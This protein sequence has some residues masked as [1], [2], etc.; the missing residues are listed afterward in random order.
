MCKLLGKPTSNSWPGFFDV[1]NH[2]HLLSL[3]SEYKS[4]TLPEKFKGM[5]ENCLDL[6]H[7]LLAWNPDERLTVIITTLITIIR[8]MRH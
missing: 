6:L 1:E 5:S 7:G 3:V 4:N 2:K 8:S